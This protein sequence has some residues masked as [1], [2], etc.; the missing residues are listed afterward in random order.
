MEWGDSTELSRMGLSHKI[1]FKADLTYH[2]PLRM[3]IVY[4]T[5]VEWGHTS[6]RTLT[7]LELA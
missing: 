3:C 4:P 5:L 2:T 6:T 7:L 1:S